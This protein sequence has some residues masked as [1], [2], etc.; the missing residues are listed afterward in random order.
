MLQ[1]SSKAFRICARCRIV[2]RS[3]NKKSKHCS[4]LCADTS[5]RKGEYSRRQL[6][7]RVG[8]P[9]RVWSCKR[10]GGSV[11]RKQQYCKACHVLSTKVVTACAVCGI[12]V[13]GFRSRPRRFCSKAC[14]YVG[15]LSIGNPHFIDGRTPINKAIRNSPEYK[16]WRLS[17]FE[18]DRYTCVMC[19]QIG[20]E[21]HADHIKPFSKYPELRLELSNGRT[22]CRKCHEQTPTFLSGSRK[23]SVDEVLDALKKS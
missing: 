17:V 14:K 8:K 20:W 21:L 3:F 7:P 4:T 22:L 9:R 23:R 12:R 18:R 11:K 6:R 5:R 2:Y 10:C 1:K 16:R 13:A 15:Y 19:G